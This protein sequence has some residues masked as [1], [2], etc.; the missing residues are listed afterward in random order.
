[1][2]RRSN[3]AARRAQIVDALV[4]VMATQG[5]AGASIADVGRAAGLAPGLIHYHFADKVEILV[6]A[7]RAIAAAHTQ[8][9]DAA[10]AG[11]GAPAAQLVAF[12]DVHLGLGAHAAPAALACWVT[13]MAEA[14]REPRVRAEVER[15]LAALV[16]RATAI[17]AAGR[18]AKVFTCTDAD[19]AAAALVATIQGYFT[20]AVTARG[21]IPA[22]SAAPSTLR[23]AAGLVGAK[24]PLARRRR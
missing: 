2:A 7:V 12:I 13:A 19:A 3:T 8:A 17:I 4:E 18:R 14:L 9:L 23:M 6:E 11:A 16:A 5:Y 20:V 10:V 1:M 24:A 21:L 22:G 15:T